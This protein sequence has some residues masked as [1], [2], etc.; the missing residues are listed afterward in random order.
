MISMGFLNATANAVFN[1]IL[2]QV[3]GLEGIALSTSMMQTLVAIVFYVRFEKRIKQL[4]E[5]P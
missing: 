3:L 2:L 4:M 1:V 5:T